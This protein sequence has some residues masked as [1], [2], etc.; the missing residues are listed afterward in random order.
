MLCLQPHV[1]AA[2]VTASSSSLTSASSQVSAASQ[3]SAPSPVSASAAEVVSADKDQQQLD[4]AEDG[5]AAD[6]ETQQPVSDDVDDV[7]DSDSKDTEAATSVSPEADVEAVDGVDDGRR[8]DDEV[9]Q[10]PH[11]APAD[12]TPPLTLMPSDDKPL[13]GSDDKPVDNDNI[14]DST[15]ADETGDTVATPT[16]A[17]DEDVTDEPMQPSSTK[18]E[19]KYQYS[20][21]LFAC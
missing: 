2:A 4:T 21:G 5:P 6:D 1:T 9:Q 19:L 7:T 12:D 8:G 18:P 13:A 20:E 17:N 14:D 10:P 3:V 11:P 16:A 15:P